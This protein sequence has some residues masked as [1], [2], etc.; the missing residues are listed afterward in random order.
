M[1]EQ[2][3]RLTQEQRQHTASRIIHDA[4]LLR[5]G[6][7]IRDDG[8]LRPSDDQVRELY[9]KNVLEPQVPEFLEKTPEGQAI[10]ENLKAVQRLST[11]INLALG[12]A[13]ILDTTRD[14]PVIDDFRAYA[15]YLDID[16]DR[17]DGKGAEGYMARNRYIRE[18][19]ARDFVTPLND[20]T[21]DLIEF[22]QFRL[23]SEVTVGRNGHDGQPEQLEDGWQV[24][25]IVVNG[26]LG[27]SRQVPEGDLFKIVSVAQLQQWNTPPEQPQA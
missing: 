24:S 1:S 5:H 8:S 23:G 3:P 17:L 13:V 21:L 18:L 26:E 12:H 11:A 9:V 2:V 22:P 25:H 14:L 15:D 10:S 7:E 27:V 19:H 6:A 4:D 16:F 20:L